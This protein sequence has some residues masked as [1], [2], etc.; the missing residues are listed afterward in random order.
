MQLYPSNT[1]TRLNCSK[2]SMPLEKYMSDLP[3]AVEAPWRLYF[4]VLVKGSHR[5]LFVQ[6]G[7]A[8]VV[9]TTHQTTMAGTKLHLEVTLLYLSSPLSVC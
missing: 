2:H 9:A 3:E 6:P 4:V 7:D 1:H 5:Y 8:L